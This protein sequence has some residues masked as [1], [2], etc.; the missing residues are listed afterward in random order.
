MGLDTTAGADEGERPAV[1][2]AEGID[3]GTEAELGAALGGEIG[4]VN[5]TK[6]SVGGGTNV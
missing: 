4:P 3:E 2:A 1:G 6:S 5:W